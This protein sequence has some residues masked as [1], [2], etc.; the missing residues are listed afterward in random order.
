MRS[1]GLSV[2]LERFQ[3]GA[4]R[5]RFRGIIFAERTDKR[6]NRAEQR[7][8]LAGFSRVRTV[9]RAVFELVPSHCGQNA[10]INVTGD[11][12]EEPRRSGSLSSASGCAAF[13][14]P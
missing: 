9:R 11:C 14:L 10:V 7:E 8:T 6:E 5:G 1:D 3:I 12:V 4:H 2:G 13:G